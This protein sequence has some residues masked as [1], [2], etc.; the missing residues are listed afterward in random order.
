MSIEIGVIEQFRRLFRGREDAHGEFEPLPDGGKR[1]RTVKSPATPEL[2]ENHLE[3]EGPF[4]G[5]IPIR[6]DGLCYFGAIDVDNHDVDDD[7]DIVALDEAI[8]KQRIPLVACRSKSG[9]AHLYLFTK[10]PVPTK[11]IIQR[12]KSWAVLLGLSKKVEV[13]PKQTRAEVGNW[14]NLP[15]YDAIKTNRYAV[16]DGKQADLGTFLAH[17]S[18]NLVT[19]A[20]LEGDD[21][22]GDDHPFQAGPPCLIQLHR[23]G[24]PAGGRNRALYNVA[25][26]FKISGVDDWKNLVKSYNEQ[27]CEPPLDAYEVDTLINSVKEHD[28]YKYSCTEEP[29]ASVCN[30]A[31]CRRKRL[32]IGFW[33][34]GDLDASM[35]EI[36]GLVELRTDPPRYF[37]KID[38]INVE[39]APEEFMSYAKFKLVVMMAVGRIPPGMR[40]HEWEDRA[41]VILAQRTT[42][43]AP[44]DAGAFG[45]FMILLNDFL[46]LARPKGEGVKEDMTRARPFINDGRIYFRSRDLLDFLARERFRDYTDH[47]VWSKLY[48]LGAGHQQ[49]KIAG[50][51]VRA[52]HISADRAGLF[53]EAL[54]IPRKKEEPHRDF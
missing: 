4:L 1:V 6:T 54:P 7:I 32:G 38:G 25:L 27:K 28:E 40:Q 47:T 48:S 41:N 8:R 3:G 2:W 33:R 42:L 50:S 46:N 23:I 26:Y 34:Q 51:T 39:I 24:L 22:E 12:L 35:P 14:I 36:T 52:W 43:E 17:A 31:L 20:K 10:E 37:L 53:T 9:G 5:I 30:Q 49:F 16:I 21:D 44:P 18:L 11:L 29:I 45:Q 15:Y 13:F 19:Q